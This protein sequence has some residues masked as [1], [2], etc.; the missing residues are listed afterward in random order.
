MKKCEYCAKEISYFD[1]F[2]CEDCQESY[3]RYQE[4]VE[5]FGKLF[6]VVNVICIFG[7]PIGIFLFSFSKV[8]G[9]SIAS[10]CCMILGILLILLP[11]PT[12]GMIKKFK[13]RKARNLTRLIGLAVI[14]FGFSIMGFL[15]FFNA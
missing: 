2:C 14:A 3:N 15:I 8:V 6:S 13:L 12:D 11:F 7:V 4:T 9:A 1:Q 10:I 5:R